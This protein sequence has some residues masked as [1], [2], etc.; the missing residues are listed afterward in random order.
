PWQYLGWQI[1][2]M[3]IRPQNIVLDIKVKNLNDLQRLL[4]T[5]NWLRKLLGISTETL[6]PL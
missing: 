3:E 5:I 6:H 1:T 2:K 4:G